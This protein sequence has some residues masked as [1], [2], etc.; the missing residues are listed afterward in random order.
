MKTRISIRSKT[1][2]FNIY[3]DGDGVAVTSFLIHHKD[4]KFIQ[5]L[6]FSLQRDTK[7]VVVT[8]GEWDAS[9]PQNLQSSI[10]KRAIKMLNDLYNIGELNEKA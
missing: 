8:G 2:K 9:I 5:T 6:R 7:E 4:L 1:F 10:E 3:K